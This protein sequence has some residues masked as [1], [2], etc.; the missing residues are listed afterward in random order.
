MDGGTSTHIHP[1]PEHNTDFLDESA[2][3]ASRVGQRLQATADLPPEVLAVERMLREEGGATG[4]WDERDHE[5]FLRYRTQCRDRPEIY[6]ART[7]EDLPEHSLASCE[8]HE[9]WYVRFQALLQ[10]KRDAIRSWRS[11]KQRRPARVGASVHSPRLVRASRAIG[12]LCD[13]T[14]CRRQ[15]EVPSALHKTQA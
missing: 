6:C 11:N 13:F 7:A 15:R 9:R 2:W 3:P 14:C 8:Q 5:R 1:A 4:G 10:A 12:G